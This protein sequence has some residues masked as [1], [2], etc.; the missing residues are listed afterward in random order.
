MCLT[1]CGDVYPSE[2]SRVTE[3]VGDISISIYLYIYI[4][5]YI[6]I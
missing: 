6:Y 3:P 5:I 2:S 1:Q 4:Y